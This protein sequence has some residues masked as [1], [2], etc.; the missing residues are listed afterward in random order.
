MNFPARCSRITRARLAVA[1]ALLLAVAGFAPSQ[2]WAQGGN[3]LLNPASWPRMAVDKFGCLLERE[4]GYRDA[5]FNCALGGYANAGSACANVEAYFEGPAFPISRVGRI[6]A[7]L[8]GIEIAYQGGQVR[9]VTLLLKERL[10][11][12]Q[13]RQHL[14]L[15]ASDALPAH[16]STIRYDGC[17]PDGAGQICN[18]VLIEGFD[19]KGAD[20]ADCG[21]DGA[22]PEPVDTPRKE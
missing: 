13:I 1:A 9:A 16:I 5:K 21:G 22:T 4:L 19:H 6:S 20:E 10:G 12:A 18:L 8:S 2:I 7:I 15:P 11:E 14:R 3:L 17:R